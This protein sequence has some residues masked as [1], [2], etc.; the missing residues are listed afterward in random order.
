MPTSDQPASSAH[1][2]LRRSI[3]AVVESDAIHQWYQIIMGFDWKLVRFLIERLEIGQDHLVLD[4]F[5]GAGTTLVQC[6]K[7]GIQ[8][9]GIDANP[10]CVLASRVKTNWNLRPKTLHVAL[11]RILDAADLVE[12]ENSLGTDAALQYLR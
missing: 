6:K 5:C 8:S 1:P 7:Q 3:D 12:D 11:Q 10:V 4:P 2:H 9:V